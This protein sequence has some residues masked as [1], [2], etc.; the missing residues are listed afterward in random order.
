MTNPNRN[1]DIFQRAL[2]GDVFAHIAKDYGI[3]RE[4]VRQIVKKMGLT[5]KELASE[6]SILHYQH[7]CPNCKK[8]FVRDSNSKKITFCSSPCF[9]EYTYKNGDLDDSPRVSATN[10]RFPIKKYKYVYTREKT[11]AGN[12]KN[13]LEHR[14]VMEKHLGRKLETS[15]HVHHINGNG[16]DNRLEN[17][18]VISA[19]KHSRDSHKKIQSSIRKSLKKESVAPK[20]ILIKKR[21]ML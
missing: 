10:R 12:Q 3:S 13:Q 4:R 20:K 9:G 8:E 7:T 1:K 2:D 19:S 5:A 16:L 14:L 21:D 6:R 18:E 15:E 11:K 17:L